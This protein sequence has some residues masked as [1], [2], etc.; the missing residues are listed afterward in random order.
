MPLYEFKCKK[1]NRTIEVLQKYNDPPPMCK[2]HKEAHE[3]ERIISKTGFSLK[4]TGWYKD[5]YVS[6][7]KESK[8]KEKTN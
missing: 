1:C 2:D 8:N 6:K 5:G 4:G 7:S 3:T